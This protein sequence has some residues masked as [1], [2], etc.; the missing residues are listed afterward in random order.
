MSPS[1]QPA[2]SIPQSVDCQNAQIPHRLSNLTLV[3][4]EKEEVELEKRVQPLLEWNHNYRLGVPVF[5]SG[6]LFIGLSF[7]LLPFFVL[8]PHGFVALN[9]LGT[10]SIFVAIILIRGG[11]VVKALVNGKRL[12]GTLSFFT[13]FGF[14]VYFSLISPDFLLVIALFAVH[15]F[16]IVFLGVSVLSELRLFNRVFRVAF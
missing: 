3:S 2:D 4:D 11:G 10:F 5:L 13:S 14:G 16:S 12:I 1:F 6:L 7:A 15:V 8:K 9:S